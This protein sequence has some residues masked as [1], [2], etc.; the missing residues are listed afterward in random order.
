MNKKPAHVYRANVVSIIYRNNGTASY[1]WKEEVTQI[2]PR[3]NL[4]AYV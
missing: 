4:Y 1:K 2:S 3:E